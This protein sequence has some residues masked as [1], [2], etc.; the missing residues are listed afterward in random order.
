MLDR[1]FLRGWAAK[2]EERARLVVYVDLRFLIPETGA[3]V[4]R[5]GMLV[6]T[7]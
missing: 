3:E 7:I 2:G 1:S 5:N 6:R 4:S